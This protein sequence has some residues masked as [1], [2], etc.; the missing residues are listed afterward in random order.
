MRRVWRRPSGPTRQIDGCQARAIFA[1]F[2]FRRRPT[3]GRTAAAR[4]RRLADISCHITRSLHRKDRGI[5]GACSTSFRARGGA[6]SVSDDNPFDSHASPYSDVASAWETMA[7]TVD[8]STVTVDLRFYAGVDVQVAREE[9]D[10]D[11]IAWSGDGVLRHTFCAAEPG[12]REIAI[13][14]V[15]SFTETLEVRVPLTRRESAAPVR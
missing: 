1:S 15:M 7:A 8:G 6:Y 11:E 13:S 12:T 14:E 3:H 4:G 9:A 10:P 2:G 5:A